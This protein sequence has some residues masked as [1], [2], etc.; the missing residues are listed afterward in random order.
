MAEGGYEHPVY[1]PHQY[2]DGYDPGD[3]DS[4]GKDDSGGV[5]DGRGEDDIGGEDDV[6]KTTPFVPTSASTPGLLV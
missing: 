1:D 5:D 3:Y 6:N 2:D 4:R